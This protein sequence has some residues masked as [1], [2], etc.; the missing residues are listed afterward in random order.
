MPYMF[1]I[2]LLIPLFTYL[3]S[4]E[5]KATQRTETPV[6]Q[7]TNPA[8]FKCAQPA[9]EQ[10][11]LIR[12]AEEN[13]YGVRRVEFIGNRYTRDNVLRR[14]IILQEGDKFTREN[15]LKSLVRVNQLKKIIYPVEL[16]HVI[17]LLDRQDKTVDFEMCFKERRPGPR[18]HP[19]KRANLR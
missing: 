11:I 5:S 13:E 1:A 16:G 4:A 9:A 19:V 6:T 15:L 18:T 10:E 3:P 14:R 7:E 12:E 8:P 17:I 2:I